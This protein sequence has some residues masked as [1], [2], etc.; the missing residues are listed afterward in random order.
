ME[1]SNVYEK[2]V[3][4][5]SILKF[6][7]PTIAMTVFMSFYTMVDGFFVSNLIG[8]NA[9][10]AINLTAPV[11]QL[12]TAVSTML[13]TGGSAA[14]MKKMGEQKAKE[15]KEDFTFLILVNVIVGVVMCAAGYLAKD[16]I[17][18]GMSLSADVERYCV[19]YL[20]CY[21]VF[22]VPILLMN[23]FTLYMIASERGNLSLIC[24]VAG[25]ILNM[26]LDYVLIV[27]FGMGISGTAIATG[28]GYSVTAVAGVFVFSKKKSL[29]HFKKPVFRFKVLVSAAA[30]G[31]SEMAT[32]LVTGIITMLF[33]WTMLTFAGEDGVAAV[34]IIMYVLM[35]A[36]SLYTGY[37]Y[38]AAPMLSYYYGE[39]NYTK[40]KK[41]VAVSLKVIAEISLVTAAVSFLL[42]RPLVSVFASP[43]N[44]VYDLAV[45]GNRICSAALLFIGFNIFASGL[46]T[47]LSNGVVSAVLAFSRSFVFMM[48]TMIVLPRIM[49]VNG[50]WLATPAAEL[51]AL[52]LF[53]FMFSKYRK[54]Y[55]Y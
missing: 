9:L 11:I 55:K 35:F 3:T 43:D 19:E 44:P 52:A 20:S 51:M 23:N 12:V 15:A 1:N 32:A 29:L 10:S 39:Q 26:A 24:S 18:S 36:S 7:V 33:N 27:R 8:T 48:I 37:S 16:Y 47:A 49:G 53:A 40:L 42:T 54:R 25:G 4:L 34:T 38:G 28:I 22:T 41:L 50:I 46:F 45:T 13:A 17:F 21:L 14:V 2:P 5:K 6:A 31:C 30:N